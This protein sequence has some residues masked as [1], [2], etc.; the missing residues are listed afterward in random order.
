MC[1]LCIRFQL[2]LRK[3]Y[4]VHFVEVSFVHKSERSSNVT[5][6][7]VK[8]KV[9]LRFSAPSAGIAEIAKR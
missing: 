6:L 9:K 1:E 8:V 2:I 4:S 3:N 7:K 5:Q